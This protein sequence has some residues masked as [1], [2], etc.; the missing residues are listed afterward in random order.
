MLCSEFDARLHEL[1]DERKAPEQDWELQCHA[2]NC[3]RCAARLETMIRLLDSLELSQTPELSSEFA[4][5]VVEAVDPPPTTRAAST[6]GVPTRLVPL[7]VVAAGLLLIAMPVAWYAVKPEVGAVPS[8]PSPS[9]T[10]STAQLEGPPAASSPARMA[11][12][13]SEDWLLSGTL[14][15]LYSQATHERH[16][17]QMTRIA[18]D[19]R[20][21]ATPFNAALTAIRRSI[22]VDTSETEREPRATADPT[23]FSRGVWTL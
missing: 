5:R 22:R 7:M 14:V 19:L 17:K 9:S 6:R 18:D 12:D 1:L 3:P 8:P 10:N 13:A 20:P 11:T 16:R 21:I 4:Q 2:R 23:A 15:E